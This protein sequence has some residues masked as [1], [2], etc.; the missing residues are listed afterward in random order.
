M[1]SEGRWKNHGQMK[2]KPMLKERQSI[3]GGRGCLL[4]WCKIFLGQKEG[5]TRT[6]IE[7]RPHHPLTR[8]SKK[9]NRKVRSYGN[10]SV[11]I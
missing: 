3:W 2:K 11:C 9:L 1:E 5:K 10:N 7:E 4:R 6:D 8:M